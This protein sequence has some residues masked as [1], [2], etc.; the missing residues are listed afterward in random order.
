MATQELNN[1]FKVASQS[2]EAGELQAA[3]QHYERCL[4]IA[5]ASA[6]FW[7]PEELA[8]FERSATINL[9]Q[10][11][12][13][14]EQFAKALDRIAEA[15]GKSP[16]S[17]GLAIALA[18]KG[19]ALCGLGRIN[20]GMEA[21]DEAIRTQ[22]IVGALNSAD[23]MTRVTSTYLLGQ[24]QRLVDQILTSY[25]DQLNQS[26]RAEAYTTYGKIAVKRGN[27]GIAQEWFD[28]ALAEQP[29]YADAKLQMQLLRGGAE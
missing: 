24:A 4:E 19:E 16:T 22:P 12:N 11:L 6:V 20:E 25:I 27:E 2:A 9:A 10:V 17:V 3:A 7:M 14:Q 8:R 5:R 13:K 21:F 15:M 1:L 26:L 29:G 23:S 28:R 18:A